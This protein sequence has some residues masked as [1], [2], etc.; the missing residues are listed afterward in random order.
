MGSEDVY[1][2][3]GRGRP[4]SQTSSVHRLQMARGT[5]TGR[6]TTLR[7]MD[8]E[9]EAWVAEASMRVSAVADIA[10]DDT[11]TGARA[12]IVG[13]ARSALADAVLRARRKAILAA[14]QPFFSKP[15]EETE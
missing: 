9:G 15:I 11:L 10:T 8:V 4:T 6:L 3:Q 7:I 13:I 2:R 12:R 1:K 14:I 5:V